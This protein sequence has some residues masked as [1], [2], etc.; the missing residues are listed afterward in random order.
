MSELILLA[1]K[2]PNLNITVSLEDLMKF[3]EFIFNKAKLEYEKV[4]EVIEEVYVTPKVAIE[5]LN[6]G[7]STLY[8]WQKQNYLNH[9]AV[10]GKRRYRLSDIK[11]ILGTNK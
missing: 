4:E 2:Y 7:K 1:E 9:V 5:M 11:K 3:G 10:G 8:R 6:I